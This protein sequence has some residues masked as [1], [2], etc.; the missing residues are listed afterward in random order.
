MPGNPVLGNEI[1]HF[2]R[3]PSGQLDH[4]MNALESKVVQLLLVA[5]IVV[6]LLSVFLKWLHRALF[7]KFDK[8]S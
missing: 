3:M 2:V 1:A 7:R 6:G 5:I 4:L 8:K